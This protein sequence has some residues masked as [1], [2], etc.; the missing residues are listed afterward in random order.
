MISSTLASP[1]SDHE[2]RISL[3]VLATSNTDNVMM[4]GLQRVKSLATR[5]FLFASCS[6]IAS[7]RRWSSTAPH[8]PLRVLFCG[9][10]QFSIF[11]LKALND[12]RLKYP[13]KVASIDVVCKKDKRVGRGLKNWQEGSMHLSSL[14][15]HFTAEHV[16]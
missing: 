7:A 2:P 5:R 14:F 11:S 16:M 8:D 9:A 3:A 12:V 6:S 10:D 13:D 4:L 15:S 1:D